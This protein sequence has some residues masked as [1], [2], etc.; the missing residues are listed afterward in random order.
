MVRSILKPT[1]PLSPPKQIPP[2]PNSRKSSPT[3]SRTG[4]SPKRSPR[5]SPQKG[6]SK[7]AARDS[8]KLRQS[9]LENLP[10]PFDEV[11]NQAA[12]NELSQKTRIAL[13]TEEQQQAATKE[14]ERKELIERRDARRKSLGRFE[15]PSIF[16]LRVV[17]YLASR[18]QKI[19]HSLTI[20]QAY[21]SHC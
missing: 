9:G 1:I 7:D 4:F 13:R 21:S 17:T 16:F 8:G 15:A 20:G 5:K 18:M 12:D 19:F 3:K 10:N 6:E 2:H 14:R 11:S